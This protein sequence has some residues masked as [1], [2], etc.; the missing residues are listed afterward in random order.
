M[1]ASTLAPFKKNFTI[2]TLAPVIATMCAHSG[3]FLRI[4]ANFVMCSM[5]SISLFFF[6]SKVIHKSI[7]LPEKPRPLAD[8]PNKCNWAPK[9]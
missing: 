4:L 2:G 7:S 9:K 3:F 1:S 6:P 5:Q 8:E